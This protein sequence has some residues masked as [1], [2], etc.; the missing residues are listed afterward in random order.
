MSNVTANNPWILDSAAVI[1][2]AKVKVK[3]MEYHPA[4]TGQTIT[5]EDENGVIVWTRTAVFDASH[6]G[7]QIMDTPMTFHGFEVAVITAGTLYVWVE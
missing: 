6:N 4:A 1:T 5:I 7:V 2:D 3:R